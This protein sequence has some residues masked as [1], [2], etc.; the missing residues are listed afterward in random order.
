M[1]ACHIQA[2]RICL[3]VDTIDILTYHETTKAYKYQIA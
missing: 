2:R 1:N 3:F